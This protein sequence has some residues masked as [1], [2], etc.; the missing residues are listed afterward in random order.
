MLA[1]CQLR[2]LQELDNAQSFPRLWDLDPAGLA[3]AAEQAGH[4]EQELHAEQD[5]D[6]GRVLPEDQRALALTPSR[7]FHINHPSLCAC[8]V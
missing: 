3:E 4:F 7:D 1:L 5:E 6:E 2:Q 8:S